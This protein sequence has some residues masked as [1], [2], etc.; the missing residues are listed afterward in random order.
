M[1][2]ILLFL[3]SELSSI[4]CL[5]GA[6]YLMGQGKSGWGWLLLV[7]VLSGISVDFSDKT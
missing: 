7:A 2:K 1:N 3:V 5:I 4:I 6:I